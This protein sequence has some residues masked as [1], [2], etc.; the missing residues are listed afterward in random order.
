VLG[1]V[2]VF[3]YVF[4]FVFAFE[5]SSSCSSVQVRVRVRVSEFE[6]SP[7]S[8]S[9]RSSIRF[10]NHRLHTKIFSVSKC[11]RALQMIFSFQFDETL[12]RPV[13]SNVLHLFGHSRLSS[14]S[15]VLYQAPLHLLL[16]NNNKI[17]HLKYGISICRT[18]HQRKAREI[19]IKRFPYKRFEFK[20]SYEENYEIYFKKVP[21][22]CAR[23]RSKENTNRGFSIRDQLD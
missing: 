20:V 8:R 9:A 17:N 2:Q 11:Y 23:E 16:F 1:K 7:Y 12:A 21:S 6:R 18:E 14:T 4:E 19:S 22:R 15:I 10:A 5:C 13:Y 3:E